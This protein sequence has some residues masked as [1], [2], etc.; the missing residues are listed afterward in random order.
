MPPGRVQD[1]HADRD[2][3]SS[4]RPRASETSAD[5][6]ISAA[7]AGGTLSRLSPAGVSRLQRAA[8]NSTVSRAL[9]VQRHEEGTELPTLDEDVT[10]ATE[11]ASEPEP[12]GDMGE[13]STNGDGAAG[14]AEET[15]AAD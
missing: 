4:R 13:P 8:G 11:K 6:A 12:T 3:S 9:A 15:P 5:A 1:M 2:D 14:P 7:A 10:E